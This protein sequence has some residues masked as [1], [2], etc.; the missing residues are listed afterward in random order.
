MVQVC[1]NMDVDIGQ[2]IAVTAKPRLYTYDAYMLVLPRGRCLP[3]LTLDTKPQTAAR[4][5]GLELV[6]L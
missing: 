5:L 3:I 6:E 2:V 4:G 1:H